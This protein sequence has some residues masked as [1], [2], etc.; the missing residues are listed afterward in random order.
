MKVFKKYNKKQENKNKHE[1]ETRIS[2]TIKLV[3]AIYQNV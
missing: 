1:Q 2:E 3:Y